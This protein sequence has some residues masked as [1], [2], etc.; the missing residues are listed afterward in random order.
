MEQLPP[1]APTRSRREP[2]PP[3][4][5][6]PPKWSA[7]PPRAPTRFKKNLR[8]ARNCASLKHNKAKG[9]DEDP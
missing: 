7:P 6:T 2:R 3:R 5:S 9:T 4:E 8:P 1:R